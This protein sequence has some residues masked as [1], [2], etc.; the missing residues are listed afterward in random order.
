M[1][2][3]V[4]GTAFL[5]VNG[6]QY[7]LRGNFVIGPSRLERTGVSGQDKIHGYTEMPVVPFI[8]GDIT[9]TPDMD[10]TT[11]ESLTDVTVQANL[12]NGQS[13]VLRNAWV[14]NRRELQTRDGMANVRFEGMDCIQY[15]T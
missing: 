10:W 9:T 6:A 13:Y 7:P 2:I 4:G 15:T 14:A 12:I 1:G 5:F 11:V 3:P 8:S